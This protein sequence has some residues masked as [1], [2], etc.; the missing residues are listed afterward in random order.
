MTFSRQYSPGISAPHEPRLLQL[1]LLIESPDFSIPT[2]AENELV[3]KHPAT[4]DS[5]APEVLCISHGGLKQSRKSHV[6][7]SSACYQP[8][9]ST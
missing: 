4:D 8:H 1:C 6:I 3:S 9:I 5:W 2:S 7:E